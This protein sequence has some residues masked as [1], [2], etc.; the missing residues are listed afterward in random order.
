MNRLKKWWVGTKAYELNVAGRHQEAL[1]K[2]HSLSNWREDAWLHLLALLQLAQ[3]RRHSEVIA[4]ANKIIAKIKEKPKLTLDRKYALAYVC[5]VRNLSVREQS[6]LSSISELN[7]VKLDFSLDKVS[8]Y[9]KK[10]FPLR[11]HPEWD[12]S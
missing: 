1:E 12:G 9:L 5:W 10:A 7:G 8:N 3:L 4:E 6:S 11:I 2:I